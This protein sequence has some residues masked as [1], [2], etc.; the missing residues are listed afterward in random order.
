MSRV[1]Y[2]HPANIK[3]HGSKDRI[4]HTVDKFVVYFGSLAFL[5]WQTLVIVLWIVVNLMMFIKHWDPY[6]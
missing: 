3:L 6:P 2:L 1:R 5:G 4:D